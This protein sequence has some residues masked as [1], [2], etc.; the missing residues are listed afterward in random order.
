MINEKQFLDLLKQP[1]GETLDFK[2]RGYDLSEDESQFDLIV[3]ILCMANTPRESTSFI[4]LG[5]NKHPDGHMI[6]WGLQTTL[7]RPTCKRNLQIM[8]ILYLISHIIL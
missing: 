4:I 2:R 6:C 3:D 7:M 8:F 5:V 1:E